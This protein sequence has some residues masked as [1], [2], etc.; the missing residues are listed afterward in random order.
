LIV[1]T[2]AVLLVTAGIGKKQ[3]AWKRQRP[4]PHPFRR[5]R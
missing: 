4:K 3:L 1:L 5:R 2:V